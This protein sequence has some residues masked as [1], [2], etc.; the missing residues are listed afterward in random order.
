M[1]SDEPRLNIAPS[2]DVEDSTYINPG[3]YQG[4]GT[5]PADPLATIEQKL[6]DTFTFAHETHEKF[7]N[8]IFGG[9]FRSQLLKFVSKNRQNLAAKDLHGIKHILKQLDIMGP[10]YRAQNLF[11]TAAH[12]DQLGKW[13]RDI[14]QPI[15]DSRHMHQAAGVAPVSRRAASV[16][17]KPVRT[18]TDVR[19]DTVL[20][21]ISGGHNHWD[22]MMGVGH[23]PRSKIIWK[24]S[25]IIQRE[26]F[27][28]PLNARLTK[29]RD[30]LVMEGRL[31]SPPEMPKPRGR[32]WSY[33]HALCQSAT[34]PDTTGQP[35]GSWLVGACDKIQG[36]QPHTTTSQA[37]CAN[38]GTSRETCPAALNPSNGANNSKT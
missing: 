27:G 32:Q 34:R 5:Q 30:H 6:H 1:A 18:E 8:D 25:G 20:K 9:T 31:E 24:L 17:A 22:V 15:I 23:V 29:L 14:I 4:T 12:A 28:T 11:N 13:G 10:L 36:A 19:F 7:E 16:Q 37:P 33:G 35:A 38:A 26:P 2:P 21:A 3:W